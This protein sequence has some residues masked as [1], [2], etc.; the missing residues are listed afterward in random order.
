[1]SLVGCPDRR[2]GRPSHRRRLFVTFFADL[3]LGLGLDTARGG[4]SLP[5]SLGLVT[6][7]FRQQGGGEGGKPKGNG[8]DEFGDVHSSDRVEQVL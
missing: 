3:A 1:M 8:G 7:R 6:A 4:A 5:R 2:K